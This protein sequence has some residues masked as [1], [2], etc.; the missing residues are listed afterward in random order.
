MRR[1][2]SC[3]DGRLPPWEAAGGPSEEAAFEL[4]PE[5]GRRLPGQNARCLPRPCLLPGAPFSPLLCTKLP[6]PVPGP[7]GQ[8]P[9]LGVGGGLG[10][11]PPPERGACPSTPQLPEQTLNTATPLESDAPPSRQRWKSR[12]VKRPAQG[13]TASKRWRRGLHWGFTGCL[14]ATVYLPASAQSPR[15]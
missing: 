15:G 6:L 10:G 8:T 4:R 1:K 11:L 13:H 7:A 12:E 3:F 9:P 5:R 14:S 2:G